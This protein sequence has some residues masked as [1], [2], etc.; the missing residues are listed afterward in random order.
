[1]FIMKNSRHKKMKKTKILYSPPP[2]D[3]LCWY[4]RMHPS[5]FFLWKIRNGLYNQFYM[6]LLF[7]FFIFMSISPGESFYEGFGFSS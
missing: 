2:R 1:M 6:L 3:N 5:G 4:F 7:P